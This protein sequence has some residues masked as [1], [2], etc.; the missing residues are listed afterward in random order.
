LQGLLVWLHQKMQ[1][2]SAWL[3]SPEAAA[4]AADFA[5]GDEA[6]QS[7]VWHSTA[8]YE[9]DSAAAAAAAV[10]PDLSAGRS[11]GSTAAYRRLLS[12]QQ[13]HQQ[14]GNSSKGSADAEY[15]RAGCDCDRRPAFAELQ[16]NVYSLQVRAGCLG[17]GLFTQSHKQKETR[18]RQAV[19]MFR[20]VN[21][22]TVRS[23]AFMCIQKLGSD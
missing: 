1:C 20:P 16:Y 7:T 5:V 15:Q 14:Q 17:I 6:Q 8:Q 11:H 13:Q 23:C 3:P 2:L 4:A 10:L 12:L 22:D 18:Q 19:R 21:A 9:E